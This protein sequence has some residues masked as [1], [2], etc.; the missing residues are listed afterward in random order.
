MVRGSS[1]GRGSG[2]ASPRT[3][4]G[5]DSAQ[6]STTRL[7]AALILM[8][9]QLAPPFRGRP[10]SPP[11]S[12]LGCQQQHHNDV[13]NLNQGPHYYCYPH[14]V[15]CC[16]HCCDC[17]CYCDGD[18]DGDANCSL[19]N[20][21]SC[22]NVD[23]PRS[24]HRQHNCRDQHHQKGRNV[25]S[26]ST[27]Y[28]STRAMS[29]TLRSKKSAHV[30]VKARWTEIITSLQLRCR[31]KQGTFATVPAATAGQAKADALRQAPH[32]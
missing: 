6:Q 10:P 2:A 18:G 25:D 16:R 21:L 29:T 20:N 26:T 27:V 22:N 3:R 9:I 14:H 17:Y 24:G 1:G 30:L 13:G 32:L 4:T 8:H 15:H 28:S 12:R 11:P 31:S 5:A 7:Q 19:L 23:D